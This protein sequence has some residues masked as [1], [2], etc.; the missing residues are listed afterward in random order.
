MTWYIECGTSYK[1]T[2][3]LS[4]VL[5]SFINW[6]HLQAFQSSMY[7][8]ASTEPSAAMLEQQ[9]KCNPPHLQQ[10][11]SSIINTIY[12]RS[13]CIRSKV[14]LYTQASLELKYIVFPDASCLKILYVLNFDCTF[15]HLLGNNLHEYFWLPKKFL[16]H[17][18]SLLLYSVE[19]IEQTYLCHSPKVNIPF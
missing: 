18:D 3:L 6:C 7:M 12:S 15:P 16:C 2:R 9:C 14:L 11:Q 17:G 4:I 13:A 5:Y 8:R 10:F 19:C 1:K